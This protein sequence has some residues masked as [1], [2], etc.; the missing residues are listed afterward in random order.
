MSVL[1]LY[2][3]ESTDLKNPEP[4]EVARV[5]ITECD[6]TV[7]IGKVKSSHVNP[8]A[9]ISYGAMGVHGITPEMVAKAPV[10]TL[11]KDKYM[12]SDEDCFVGSHN[13]KFDSKVLGEDYDGF[14]SICTLELARKLIDK[15]ECDSHTNMALYY[16]LGLHKT[17][18]FPEGKPHGAAFDVQITA[19]ILVELMKRFSLTLQDCYDIVNEIKE[20]DKPFICPFPKHKGKTWEQVLVDDSRYVDWV[21]ENNK[22]YDK[23]EHDKLRKLVKRC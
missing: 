3:T 12:P 10:W 15:S 7:L 21:L 13:W 4:V 6:N 23:T 5:K 1:F 18:G 14:K 20:A 11:V 2:D 16:Y 9:H 22:L 19:N 17:V 8:E